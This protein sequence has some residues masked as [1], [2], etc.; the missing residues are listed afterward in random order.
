MINFNLAGNNNNNNT[1]K[2]E[3]EMAPV[4]SVQSGGPAG[5]AGPGSGQQGDSVDEISM[6]FQE[7]EG[8]YPHLKEEPITGKRL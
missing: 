8:E 2:A 1:S 7:L 3:A 5:Q 6:F 4:Y